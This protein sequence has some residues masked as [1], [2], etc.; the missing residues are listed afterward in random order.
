MKWVN[1]LA[2]LLE[3]CLAFA[4]DWLAADYQ[5]LETEVGK[6]EAARA[7][8]LADLEAAK[9]KHRA[10]AEAAANRARRLQ[11]DREAYTVP[12]DTDTAELANH[13]LSKG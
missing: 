10:E 2:S 1:I 5:R 4:C 13:L 9:A 11:D 7:G 6:R 3:W 8:L 12:E